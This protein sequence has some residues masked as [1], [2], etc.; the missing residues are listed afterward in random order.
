MEPLYGCCALCATD[1]KC[2]RC[3]SCGMWH[4]DHAA[5]RGLV[6]LGTDE[7]PRCAPTCTDGTPELV[8]R[9]QLLNGQS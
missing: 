3:V 1:S 6:V 4:H 7:L 2:Q 5:T 9:R 8:R